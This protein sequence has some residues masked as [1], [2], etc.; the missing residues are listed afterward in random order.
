MDQQ[1][2]GITQ[3]SSEGLFKQLDA[4]LRSGSNINELLTRILQ[5]GVPAEQLAVSL[6]PIANTSAFLQSLLKVSPAYAAD[7]KLAA[8]SHAVQPGQNQ[9]RPAVGSGHAG[10]S[11]HAEE[12]EGGHSQLANRLNGAASH[13]ERIHIAVE[14]FEAGGSTEDFIR[15]SGATKEQAAMIAR[16]E[17]AMRAEWDRKHRAKREEEEKRRLMEQYKLSEEEAQRRASRIVDAERNREVASEQA[18]RHPDV[19]GIR[20]NESAKIEIEKM[21]KA[22]RMASIQEAATDKNFDES[23]AKQVSDA[24]DGDREKSKTTQEAASSDAFAS[25]VE[26]TKVA[27]VT[28]FKAKL[29]SM[30]P[31]EQEAAPKAAHTLG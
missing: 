25:L 23:K 21:A 12:A 6:G 28:D 16:E 24:K 22:G 29:A 13:E 4:A 19:A 27:P 18:R 11:G 30:K 15:A 26:D 10:P 7:F 5:A 17:K 1:F 9:N 3:T 8:D 14:H 2:Q 20:D 31:T